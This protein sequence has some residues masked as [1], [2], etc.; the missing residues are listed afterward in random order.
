MGENQQK[1]PSESS[2]S[3]GFYSST[4]KQVETMAIA[5]KIH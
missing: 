2:W 1:Q 4:K 3:D 5:K